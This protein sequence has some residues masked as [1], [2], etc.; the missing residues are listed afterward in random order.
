MRWGIP[1]EAAAP[2]RWADLPDSRARHR[3]ELNGGLH[4]SPASFDT[5]HR[6]ALLLSLP[7]ESAK[8]FWTLS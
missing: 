5:G 1:L 6:S 7:P 4:G 3:R 8:S 2:R